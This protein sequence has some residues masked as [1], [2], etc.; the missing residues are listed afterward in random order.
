MHYWR[1]GPSGMMFNRSMMG[2]GGMMGGGGG[3]DSYSSWTWGGEF[4]CGAEYS[5][6]GSGTMPVWV[7]M[8]S[9]IL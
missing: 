5:G 4:R 7:N 9:A 3:S 6:L 2:A 8:T 1:N